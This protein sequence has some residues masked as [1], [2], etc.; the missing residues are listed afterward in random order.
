MNDFDLNR[1]LYDLKQKQRASQVARLKSG[2]FIWNELLNNHFLEYG[3]SHYVTDEFEMNQIAYP[4]LREWDVV[5]IETFPKMMRN[6]VSARDI[7]I[8]S[9]TEMDDAELFF[10][11][12]LMSYETFK[13]CETASRRIA[14]ERGKA[15]FDK[16]TPTEK[17]YLKET[18]RLADFCPNIEELFRMMIDRPEDKC[19]IPL[20]KEYIDYVGNI[21]KAAM[22]MRDIYNI[23][24]KEPLIRSYKRDDLV[25]PD[26]LNK[27]HLNVLAHF[28]KIRNSFY[29]EK[30]PMGADDLDLGLMVLAK[31]LFINQ[32][33]VLENLPDNSRDLLLTT[34]AKIANQIFKDV[35]HHQ[36][37]LVKNNFNQYVTSCAKCLYDMIMVN[38]HVPDHQNYENALAFKQSIKDF[39]NPMFKKITPTNLFNLKET[40]S[41][42]YDE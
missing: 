31:Q 27:T 24:A 42:E 8:V 3:E 17:A 14:V 12:G 13:Y 32:I 40:P 30:T 25:V 4:I 6:R 16:K 22:I 10:T 37:D 34:R 21:R 39:M 15:F 26:D 33:K 38:P 36:T 20:R 28:V 29:R 18:M 2:S 35:C 19:Q 11:C 5:L 41:R 7:G 23:N 9:L 1:R